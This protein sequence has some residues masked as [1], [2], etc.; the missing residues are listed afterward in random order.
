LRLQRIVIG[1]ERFVKIGFR[2]EGGFVGGHDRDTQRP[3][4]NHISAPPEDIASLTQKE[5]AQ[6]ETLYATAFGAGHDG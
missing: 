4:P 3:I 5:V 6:I 2:R 1:D